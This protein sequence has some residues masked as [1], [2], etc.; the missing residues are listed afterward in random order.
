M[1]T[2]NR[3]A[4][5]GHLQGA[6]TAG[7]PIG[8]NKKSVILGVSTM[9]PHLLHPSDPLLE[10]YDPHYNAC[11][12]PNG[13]ENHPQVDERIWA[14]GS[15]SVTAVMEY[16]QNSNHTQSQ[17]KRVI[18]PSPNPRTCLLSMDSG[19][20]VYIHSNNNKCNNNNI[21]DTKPGASSSEQE[22]HN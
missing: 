15:R 17:M 11:H 16:T 20:V 19:P 2:R 10:G 14:K 13:R 22:W 9:W 3:S 12:K 4:T 8:M 1:I 5:D 18:C 7:L 6:I 21:S